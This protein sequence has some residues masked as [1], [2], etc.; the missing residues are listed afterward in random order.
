MSIAA[1]SPSKSADVPGLRSQS[2]IPN[3]YWRS[4]DELEQ[5]PEFVEFLHR[6]FPVAASEFPTGVSR[7]RWLQIMGASL[8][9][10]GVSGCRWEREIIAPFVNR[11][12][13]RIPGEPQ[14]FASAFEIGGVVRPLEVTAF[15]GRPIKV[16]GNPEHPLNGGGSDG[17]TQAM[18]LHLY[19]PDR[20]RDVAE[21]KAG[22]AS[23]SS[24][25]SYNSFASKLFP[26]AATSGGKGLRVLA[27]ISS[28][29]SRARLKE[30]FLAK[31]PEAK[32]YEYEAVS[33]DNDRLGTVKAFGKPLRTVIDLTEA[34]TIVALDADLF[35]SHPQ[36]T[37]NLRQW[38]L[39]RD[40]EAGPMN[41]M[42][43]AESQLSSAGGAADH[44]LA[45]RS[46][47]MAS[48][49]AKLEKAV[50]EVLSGK[51]LSA[52]EGEPEQRWI[53]AAAGDLVASKGK[54]LVV[55]GLLHGEDVQARAHRLNST[56][57]N[58]GKT[59]RFIADPTS[60]GD[61][62]A[63][64]SAEQLKALTAE[65]AAGQVDI[66]LVLGGNPVYAAPKE[67][68][69]ADA[70]SKVKHRIHL[71]EYVDETSLASTW[72]LARS[73]QL[74][75]WA[76][77]KSWDGRLMLRQ[78][79]ISPIFSTKSDLEVLAETAGEADVVSLDIV[80]ATLKN[81]LP[82]AGF[83]EEFRRL[84]H[85]GFRKEEEIPVVEVALKEG[86]AIPEPTASAS[87]E[88]E[89]VFVPS[90]STFDGR[91]ANNGWLQ[92][93]PD[94]LTKVTWDN[95][96]VI[97]PDTAKQLKV[98]YGEVISLAVGQGSIDLPVY[99]LPGQAL[100]SIGV[101]IGYG[102]TAA[103]HVGGLISADVD[104]V[105]V[106]TASI[107][108]AGANLVVGAKVAKTGRT[109]KLATTQDH[110]NIDV[111][112]MKQ[113]A[114]TVGKLV[115]EGT[116]EDYKSHPDF[117]Q[118][119]VHIPP[120]DSLW[121]DQDWQKPSSENRAW[122]M[123][124]DLSKCVGCNAC[125]IACQSENNVPIVGRDQVAR[126]RE[127]HWLRI[128]RYFKGP[129]NDPQMV[130][131]PLTCQQCENAPCEQVCPVA[132]TAHSPEGLNDMAYNRCVGTRYCA[133]NCPYKV[134]RFN[135]LD[136][137]KKYET[138]Q[139]DGQDLTLLIL[140]PEVTV[141]ERGVMEKCTYCVQRIQHVKIV[142]KNEQREIRDGEIVTACQQAC[143][144]RAIEFGDLRQSDWN[145]SKNHNS[146][147]AYAILAELNTRP[148]TKYLARIRNLHPELAPPSEHAHGGHGSHGHDDHGHGH[149]KHGEAKHGDHA[150]GKDGHD[151][152]D[153]PEK[154]ATKKPEEAKKEAAA[155]KA[156][157]QD[158]LK[159]TMLS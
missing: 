10:A 3:E 156:T 81:I 40:P 24:W 78:P 158:I 93:A 108:P 115:R 134:R 154:P 112:G 142:A 118:H 99:L 129:E 141:R 11:P 18:L 110:H 56:L 28:S 159:G 54:S 64:S 103:G 33:F 82:V 9:L 105:G 8:A 19:D 38:A 86:L 15:D 80:R 83:T 155:R 132:A 12:S 63:P 151:D 47:D 21:I 89:V 26:A 119:V 53:H 152:H 65:M 17:Y 135:F 72:H 22:K 25:D 77:L 20:S 137:N 66:A 27:E 71:S 102:R 130:M 117:A 13:D 148:R 143:P 30:A 146:P 88:I 121:P 41:R 1:N 48:L 32:W 92:E 122:G 90:T 50:G 104:P 57:G 94:P 126:G 107:K 58:I 39:R 136:Y 85:D 49:L 98:G 95:A 37:A 145:V 34:D 76:D 46:A 79:L 74:E 14:K 68:G 127:M 124:I 153:H 97:S 67:I 139:A 51:T 113:V 101:A 133:N 44:R 100:N 43:V 60:T 144:A 75:S 87:S 4:L 29:A 70:Y 106:D 2:F 114:Q 111:G 7:R 125:T 120:L 16:D 96:A 31:F 128:D 123:S 59:V 52:K 42:Y 35:G 55:V 61:Q 150:H 140:N 147:R 5:T 131:Q 138:A 84:A 157:L 36:A 6:E 62:A 69:F 91:F 23:P 73:H 149:D 109:Y 45:V 116:L